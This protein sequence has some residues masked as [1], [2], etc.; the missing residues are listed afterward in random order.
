[1]YF[2]FCLAFRHF[3]LLCFAI[4]SVSIYFYVYHCIKAN[5]IRY[6]IRWLVFCIEAS[7]IFLH[8]M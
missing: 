6:T 4:S 3:A 2:C 5:E 8:L 1:M 7:R